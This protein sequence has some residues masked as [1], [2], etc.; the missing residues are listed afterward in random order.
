MVRLQWVLNVR[1]DKNGLNITSTRR[2]RESVWKKIIKKKIKH[3]SSF[4]MV[5]VFFSLTVH[6]FWTIAKC[7]RIKCFMC[8]S[9]LFLSTFVCASLHDFQIWW[10][11]WTRRKRF[12]VKRINKIKKTVLRGN[13]K[14]KNTSIRECVFVF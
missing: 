9:F 2:K 12:I 8:A 6:C 11:N 1:Y 5:V 4:E 10:Q 14:N 3:E 13:L 7:K